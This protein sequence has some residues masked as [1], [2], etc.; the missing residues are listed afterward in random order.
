MNMSDPMHM[1]TTDKSIVFE[2]H[3]EKECKIPCSICRLALAYDIITETGIHRR[4]VKD[5]PLQ[6]LMKHTMST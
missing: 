5:D 4:P 2:T 6:C 3:A 1:I